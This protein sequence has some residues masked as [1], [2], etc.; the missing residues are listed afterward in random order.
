MD[1]TLDLGK[2]RK[3]KTIAGTGPCH[4]N[5]RWDCWTDISYIPLEDR[6][7]AR[8]VRVIAD[9]GSRWTSMECDEII[10]EF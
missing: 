6:P 10:V 1:V 7:S 8:Y 5:D 4:T 3:I 9:N 2:V